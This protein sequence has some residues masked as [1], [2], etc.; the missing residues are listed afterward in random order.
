MDNKAAVALS[1]KFKNNHD[2]LIWRSEFA[3]QDVIF[4]EAG[5]MKFNFCHVVARIPMGSWMRK[6]LLGRLFKDLP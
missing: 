4:V 6:L 3:G 5:W 1:I 2:R